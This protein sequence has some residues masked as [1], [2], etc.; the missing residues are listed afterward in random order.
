MKGQARTATVKALETC[1]IYRLSHRDFRKVIE[2]HREI[3]RRIE[4]IANER[5]KSTLISKRKFSLP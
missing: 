3:V 2:P 1:E 4:Q 5:I